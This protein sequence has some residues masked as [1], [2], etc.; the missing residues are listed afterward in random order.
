MRTRSWKL[1]RMM[2][3]L[4]L[5][6]LFACLGPPVESPRTTVTQE[7]NVRVE[8]NIK[9]KVDVLF[10][11][12]NS[13]SM[14]PMQIELRARFG[15]FFKV[16]EDLAASGTYADMHIGVITSDFGAGDAG[17]GGCD[18]YGGGQKGILQT[19]PSPKATNPP[20]NCMPPTGQPFISYAFTAGGTPVSNLPNGNDPTALV[21]EFTCMASVGAA[22]C[23][24]EHQLE[25]VYS[26]LHN[27]KENA[28]F[29]RSDAL[30][31]V[32]FVTNEDDGSAPQ[33]AKFYEQTTDPSGTSMY[34]QYTTYRQTRFAVEC[35]GMD[36]P[37]GM[38]TGLL[39]NCASK[40]NPMNTD[41]STAYDISRYINFFKLPAAQGGVKVDPQDV[42]LVA[43]DGPETPFQTILADPTKGQTP[44]QM[45]PSPMLSTNCI[46]ALQHSCENTVQPGFFA[47]PGVR[48]NA[49]VSSVT[50]HKISSICGD[51]LT[52]APDFSNAMEQLG[53]L[54]SSQIGP[55]CLNSPVANRADGTPDCTVEDVT[56]NKD[57]T[58]SI[59]E[60][61]SC[62][63]N[64]SMPPCWQ[65]N[66]LLSQYTMQGCVAPPGPEP[67]SCK[68]PLSCQPV[69]NPVDMKKQLASVSIN[70]GGQPPPASTTAR[71]SCATIASSM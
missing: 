21:S 15:D 53:Q 23:G 48:M 45:C 41:A 44:Y 52:K 13:I 34:G 36:I 32:V 1:V 67:A 16:F 60:I 62:A 70:R 71:V 46:V 3:P 61:P 56:A 37:Y 12:D 28:G 7:T 65:L 40:P 68:L 11:V 6:P 31:T 58:T 63:E 5:I 29:L 55:G 51:D 38:P 17:G 49:V 25:S 10:M 33:V 24:F 18:P 26:A 19:L 47:D 4:G 54:I 20:A 14:D 57:G 35:G 50:N 59:V 27:T 69:V 39:T 43:L 22:G 42:I 66:D 8:Q 2:A 30:L 9:N 64:G